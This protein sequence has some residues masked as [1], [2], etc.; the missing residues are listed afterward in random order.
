MNQPTL[1][2][3]RPLCGCL[4]WRVAL[5]FPKQS[6][7]H[8]RGYWPS[9]CSGA[10]GWVWILALSLDL[11]MEDYSRVPP[12]NLILNHIDTSRHCS[13][14]VLLL[15]WWMVK[16]QPGRGYWSQRLLLKI[17]PFFHFAFFIFYFFVSE[18]IPKGT[19]K[20][21]SWVR[22]VIPEFCTHEYVFYQLTTDHLLCDNDCLLSRHRYLCLLSACLCSCG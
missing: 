13:F 16:K 20:W 22:Q 12:S 3:V 14:F 15:R 19:V 9:V 8:P 21:F 4:R 2:T 6:K 5:S 7:E 10:R 18:H 17:N 1:L 11:F